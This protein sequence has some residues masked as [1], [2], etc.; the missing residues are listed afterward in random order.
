M[1]ELFPFLFLQL[2]ACLDHL[3][4]QVLKLDTVIEVYEGKCKIQEQDRNPITSIYGV[5]SLLNF[6]AIKSLSRAC[7]WK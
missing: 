5:V 2:L 7:I 6:L 1:T 4:K 3:I